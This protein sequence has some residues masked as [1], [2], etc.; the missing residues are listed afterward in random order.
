VVV[1]PGSGGLVVGLR[2]GGAMAWPCVVCVMCA[3]W[4]GGM[5]NLLPVVGPAWWCN[6]V[7][8]L[9]WVLACLVGSGVY[10][11]GEYMIIS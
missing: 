7:R 6:W 11:I 5:C 4:V 2:I 9:V 10:S 1:W 3:G 8:W